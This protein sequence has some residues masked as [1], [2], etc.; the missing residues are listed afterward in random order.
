MPI[1]GFGTEGSAVAIAWHM[2]NEIRR[3]WKGKD[4]VRPKDLERLEKKVDELTECST[5]TRI[6]L[7][8]ISAGVKR[9]NG[10]SKPGIVG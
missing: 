8:E 7:A 10:N 2:I 9:L 3:I 4:E 5:D 1:D 6:K